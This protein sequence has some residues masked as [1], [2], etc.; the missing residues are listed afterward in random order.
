MHSRKGQ[1]RKELSK[2]LQVQ[3]R[4]VRAKKSTIIKEK[5]FSLPEFKKAECIMF[6]A[7]K[8]DEVDTS[9]MI[10]E[11]LG[12][13]KR[14]ALPRCTS[15][16]TVIPKVIGNRKAD[17]EKSTYGI[18]EPRE[19]Q[20]NAK[21]EEIDI[22]VVPGI[23]FDRHNRRL[24]RGKGYYDKFLGGLPR[25]SVSIGIAFDFQLVKNLPYDPYDV[26]VSKVI[27]N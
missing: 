24:G 27:T 18:C 15:L 23:A 13:G 12:M 7:S 22:I 5:L 20:K 3:A 10:D 16:Q 21:L 2:Q 14:V 8:D 9:E 19:C 26:P 25:D 6:Y 17:L 11:A 1:I 4:D